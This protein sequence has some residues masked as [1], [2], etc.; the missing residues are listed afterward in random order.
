MG[1][2]MEGIVV[3][4]G[5][6][7][8]FIDVGAEKNALL[9][10]NV[11][12]S[13]QFR[14]GDIISACRVDYVNPIAQRLAVRIV[15][16]QAELAANRLPLEALKEGAVV[17]GVVT[18]QS[19]AGVFINIGA[20]RDGRLNAPHK[21]GRRFRRGQ[22]L[23]DLVISGVDLAKNQITFTLQDP[24]AALAELLMVGKPAPVWRSM[25]GEGGDAA[26]RSP[27]KKFAPGCFVDG[28]VSSITDRGIYVDL[29]GDDVDTKEFVALLHVPPQVRSEFQNG[30]RIEGM[31]IVRVTHGG[32]D[33]SLL[34]LS[35]DDPE[36][37]DD[38]RRNGMA[39]AGV[40]E[41]A[42]QETPSTEADE[43]G[44]AEVNCIVAGRLADGRVVHVGPK[45]VFIDLGSGREGVLQVPS[46][47]LGEFQEGDEVKGM[48]VDSVDSQ[49]KVILSMEDPPLSAEEEEEDA[50]AAT[51]SQATEG[52]AP[53][54]DQFAQV[55]ASGL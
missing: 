21:I 40:V 18:D 44:S 54:D 53:H 34:E 31:Q 49:G 16:M 51:E 47:F 27:R 20:A 33:G 30:D 25:G 5:P 13:W 50:P 19:G 15:D 39:K 52:H 45:D 29:V 11:K 1:A 2:I 26:P 12:D 22:V 3:N 32:P 37:E 42:L 4:V 17:D 46:E 48:L 43:F 24:E 41:Q 35:M 55:E 7:G 9:F 6:H 36:L 38:E 28:V 8:T 23:R 14:R 10:A